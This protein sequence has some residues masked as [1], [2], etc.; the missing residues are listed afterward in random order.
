LAK[1]RV[2]VKRVYV[3]DGKVIVMVDR[4]A[5]DAVGTIA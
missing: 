2:V 3:G 5:L 4:K 1:G